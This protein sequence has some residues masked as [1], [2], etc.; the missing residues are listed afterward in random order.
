MPVPM[1]VRNHLPVSHCGRI[2]T[3]KGGKTMELGYEGGGRESATG[4]FPGTL[5]VNE[6]G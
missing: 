4:V 2:L 1:V 3:G 5:R 6:L